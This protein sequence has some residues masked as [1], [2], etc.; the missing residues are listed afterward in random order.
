MTTTEQT[1]APVAPRP[2]TGIIP[3]PPA[4]ARTA[5]AAGALLTLAST[6]LAWTWTA[7]FPGDLTVNGYPGGLQVL[8]LTGAL[9]TLLITL[10]AHGVRGLTW[11]TPGGKHSPVL[12]LALGTF[13]TTWYA[14]IA[15]AVNLGGLANLE[16][17]GWIAALASLATLVAALGLPAD[18]PLEGDRTTPWKRFTHTFKAPTPEPAAPLPSW[19]EIVI[20]A[21]AFG[22]GLFVFTY[23]IDTE[24]AELFIGFMLLV[25]FGATALARTGLNHRLASYTAKHKNVTVTAAFV[26]AFTFPFTQT[27]DA[28]ATIGTN[29]LIFATVALGLNV[30]VGLAGLLDLGYVAFLGVGAYTAALVSGSPSSTIG[31]QLPFWAAVLAGAAASLIFGIVIGA[32]TLRLHGDYLAIVTLGFGEIFRLAVQNMDGVSGPNVTNGPNGIPNIPELEIFGFNLGE[33]HTILGVELGKFSNYYLL[34]LVF[35]II[36][37]TVFRRSDQSRIGRAWVAIR[38]D[39]TAARA[40]GIN[41]FR[42]KLLAFALGATLAGM[43]G[44]VQAHVTTTVTPTEFKFVEAVP[45]NSAFLLA[46]VILGGMGTVSG[47]LIGASLLYLIPAKLQ[48]MSDY[49]LLLFGVALVLLMRFRPEGLIADRRKQLEFH[50]ADQPGPGSPPKGDTSLSKAGV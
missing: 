41:A 33:S 42:L 38:E 8:T 1:T 40:M 49:Q 17:G 21:I 16:P 36:V 19:A 32:P 2:A 25:C 4:A 3:L 10:S 46:A 43:A 34:M 6:F 11:L 27:N 9:L 31:I 12:L 35:T 45:P 7:E 20:I 39:E 24:Y 47:P 50:S 30:V 48:F 28:Y 37:V 44:T 23:G 18:T 29:I 13:A 5:T 15:I 26:A 14:V 22:L